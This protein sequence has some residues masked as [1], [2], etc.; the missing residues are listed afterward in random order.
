MI[1]DTAQIVK[2]VT[3]DEASCV[4]QCQWRKGKVV[5]TNDNLV[6][7]ADLFATNFCHPPTT[8]DWDKNAPAC[9]AMNNKDA[10][11]QAQ[12]QWSTG[13]EFIPNQDFCSAST[14][15]GVATDFT[16]CAEK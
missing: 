1:K 13:K 5:A 6:A 4:D 12:C 16:S 3:S 15:S 2:C 8:T 9:L 10:C 11:N 7:G 14:I